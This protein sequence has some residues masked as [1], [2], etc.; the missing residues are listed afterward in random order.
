MSPAYIIVVKGLRTFGPVLRP[1]KLVNEQA[2]GEII[3]H[4]PSLPP[5]RHPEPM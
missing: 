3:A 4:A 1:R 2:L 5:H